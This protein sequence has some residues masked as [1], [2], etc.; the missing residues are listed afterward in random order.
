MKYLILI[1]LLAL[2][3]SCTTN[4]SYEKWDVE[5]DGRLYEDCTIEAG[6]GIYDNHMILQN[7]NATYKFKMKAVNTIIIRRK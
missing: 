1:A 3:I 2:F 7:E 4:L 6:E 5:V